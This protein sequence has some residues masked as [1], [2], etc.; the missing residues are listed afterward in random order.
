MPRASRAETPR[1][2]GA[3]RGGARRRAARFRSAIV[4]ARRLAR[5]VVAAR[6]IR[7]VSGDETLETRILGIGDRR[8]RRVRDERGHRAARADSNASGELLSPAPRTNHASRGGRRRDVPASASASVCLS[9]CL[10]SFAIAAYASCTH[11]RPSLARARGGHPG[12]RRARR[13]ASARRPGGP[14]TRAARRKKR[15]GRVRERA[16]LRTSRRSTSPRTPRRTTAE[17]HAGSSPPASRGS[18]RTRASPLGSAGPAPAPRA[19]PGRWWR[20]S[21]RRRWRTARDRRLL[22]RRWD[23]IARHR[24]RRR[25]VP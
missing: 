2:K 23:R 5:V 17:R 1:A 15:D 10:S 25:T 18:T 16:Y 13:R 19:F 12:R 6:S 11:A 14:T 24:R 7:T 4:F 22:R 20:P 3:R 9:V 21:R 8:R